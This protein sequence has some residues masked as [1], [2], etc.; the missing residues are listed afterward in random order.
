MPRRS[1]RGRGRRIK[2]ARPHT[3]ADL[4]RAQGL[5]EHALRALRIQPETVRLDYDEQADA[6]TFAVLLPVHEDAGVVSL[7]LARRLHAHTWASVAHAGRTVSGTIR[8]GHRPVPFDPWM[9]RIIDRR[10]FA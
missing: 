8:L 10:P 9:K 2:P 7:A 4:Q 1:T 6:Y 5:L 3:Q